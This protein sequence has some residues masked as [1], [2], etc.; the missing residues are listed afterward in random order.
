MGHPLGSFIQDLLAT[1]ASGE[2]QRERVSLV[3]DNARM[4]LDN[5]K[6][7]A[8]RKRFRPEQHQLPPLSLSRATNPG[9]LARKESLDVSDHTRGESRWGST[10]MTTGSS[11]PVTPSRELRAGHRQR[12]RKTASPTSIQQLSPVV[13]ENRKKGLPSGCKHVKLASA[14]H[15][16]LELHNPL[17][18]S[19]RRSSKAKQGTR[20]SEVEHKD[21]SQE[22]LYRVEEALA[23]CSATDRRS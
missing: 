21:A 20:T 10:V 2:G 23:I 4:A 1:S 9:R 6:N 7:R 19:Q 8:L 22:A 3:V 11:V 14:S 13:E 18:G 5:P 15:N 17:S 16:L 12:E